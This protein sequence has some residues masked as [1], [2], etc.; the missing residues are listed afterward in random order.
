MWTTVLAAALPRRRTVLW[1]AAAGVAIAALDL[2]PLARPFP[3]IR[4]LARGPQIADHV[5]FGAV[6]AAII[7]RSRATAEDEWPAP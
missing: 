6:A 5:A 7:R 2:G 1:G 4:A 3:R